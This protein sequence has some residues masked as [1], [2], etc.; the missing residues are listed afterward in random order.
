[1]DDGMDGGAMLKASRSL[2]LAAAAVPQRSAAEDGD[3]QR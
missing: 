1:M 3:M 2:P